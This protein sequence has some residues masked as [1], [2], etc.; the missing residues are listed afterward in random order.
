MIESEE[1]GKVCPAC[2][3]VNDMEAIRCAA[4]G[5]DLDAVAEQPDVEFIDIGDD[6]ELLHVDPENRVELERFVR[7]DEAELACGLLRSH[8]IPCELTTMVIPGL[9]T[10]MILWVRS[11]DA[12]LAWAVLADTEGGASTKDVA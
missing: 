5:A 4:C 1:R 10:D 11:Q 3:S 6:P 7:L 2:D 9:P 12:R 8:G